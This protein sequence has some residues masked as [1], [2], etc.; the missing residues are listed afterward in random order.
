MKRLLLLTCLA[1]PPPLL[2]AAAPVPPGCL[3]EEVERGTPAEA[4]GLKRGDQIVEAG[5]KTL[6]TIQDLQAAV[7]S[8]GSELSIGVKRGEKTETLTAKMPPSSRPKLG[9]QCAGPVE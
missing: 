1:F 7:R 3:I 9:V 4:I 8:A 5:G 2:A 6:A